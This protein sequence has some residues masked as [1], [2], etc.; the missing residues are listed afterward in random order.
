[1]LTLIVH[2]TNATIGVWPTLA[3]PQILHRVG[4]LL[5]LVAGHLD[6]AIQRINYGFDY[7]GVDESAVITVPS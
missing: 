1:M 7:A 3:Q 6:S 2:G 5:I 4:G